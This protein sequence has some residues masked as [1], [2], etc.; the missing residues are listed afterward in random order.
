M[1]S[2][3]A[4]ELIDLVARWIHVIAA[5]MWIGNSLLFNWMDRTLVQEPGMPPGSI[6]TT[7]LL[8]SGA[9]YHIDKTSLGGRGMPLHVHWFKYQA[10]TTWVSGVVLL[11][12]V[13]WIGGRAALEDPSLMVLSHRQAV[14][15]GALIV[16]GGVFG[17][18]AIQRYVAPRFPRIAELF[19][20]L[21][22]I[23]AVLMATQMLNGRAAFLHIGAMLASIMAANV[24]LTI[25]PSQRALVRLVESS[26]SAD[27]KLSAR[28]KRVSI[29]NN[30]FTFPVVVLMVSG[31]F[32]SLYAGRAPWAAL[33]VLIISGAVVRHILNIRFQYEA[34]QPAL[35]MTVFVSILA[36]YALTLSPSAA[37]A[38]S[39]AAAPAVVTS[40]DA[41]HIIDRRCAA[42]HSATPTDI[43]FGPA[44][45][46]VMF[47]TPE[48][49]QSRLPRIMERA[50]VSKTMPPANRTGITDQER[51]I[52]G[53][54]IQQGAH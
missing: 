44:P 21:A 19:L 35:G 25:V 50:V 15:V 11:F 24:A 47:D 22:L 42:C 23:C 12:A 45:A 26:G 10:Y 39:G 54:W 20:A 3:H 38:P 16:F 41:R 29:H 53:Q 6:G 52:L 8:H 2:A 46:G 18:E 36:L 28:A 14:G 17:Y 43:T 1:L 33:L 31:H 34:W 27:P 5:I 13:Y 9:F 4:Y 51:A 30:Y 49:I 40:A 32:P 48:Q 37:S 7:W